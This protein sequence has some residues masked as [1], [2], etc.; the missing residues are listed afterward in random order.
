MTDKELMLNYITQTIMDS[1]EV[2]YLSTNK[3]ELRVRCPYCGDSQR[4]LRKAR[5]YIEMES[6]FRY[7]CFNDNCHASGVLNSETLNKLE[8]YDSTLDEYI[9]KLNKESRKGFKIKI[10]NNKNTKYEIKNRDS[11]QFKFD[12]LN[13]RFGF[14]YDD[15]YW[16][17]NYKI[18]ANVDEF[19]KENKVRINPKMNNFIKTIDSDYLGF[20]SSDKTHCVFRDVTGNHEKMRYWNW[21]IYDISEGAHK[22]YTI[23]RQIDL[24]TEEL[25]LV[26]TEGVMDIISVYENFYKDDIVDSTSYAFA[27]AAGK[28]FETVL[29]YFIKLGFLKLKLII[30]SDNDVN[31]NYY[32]KLKRN[33]DFL[34]NSRITIYYN[35]YEGEKD[36]G[37]SKD[38]LSRSKARV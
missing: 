5:F 37:V 3:K 7:Y 11:D 23:P 22:F 8:I 31:I 20:L 25:T 35:E 14:N 12:Y 19:I 34:S 2:S 21:N 16:V 33:S 18:V 4:D 17:E 9:G 6:P 13:K 24:M 32:K 1:K 29:N 38:K 10:R 15:K 30:Y 27:A 26:M 28:G 36:F